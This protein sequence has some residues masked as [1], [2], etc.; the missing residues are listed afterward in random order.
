MPTPTATQQAST[1][2]VLTFPEQGQTYKSPITFQWQGALRSGQTYLVRV[3]HVNSGTTIQSS[4]L[5]TTS[6]TADLPGDKYGDWRWKVSVL[7]GN[8]VVAAS[9]EGMFWFNPFPGAKPGAG[10]EEPTA[11]PYYP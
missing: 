7:Q 2:P 4:P 9:T 3:W 11:E 5:S 6:W 8:S 1:T 10:E